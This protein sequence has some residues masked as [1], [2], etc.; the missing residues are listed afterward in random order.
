MQLKK[1]AY[2]N[3]SFAVTYPLAFPSKCLGVSTCIESDGPVVGNIVAYAKARTNK[4]FTL[5]LDVSSESD[6]VDVFYIA[7]GL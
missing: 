4:G 2:S 3:T 6:T 7:V 5:I 1:S